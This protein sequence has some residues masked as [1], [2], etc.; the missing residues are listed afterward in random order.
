MIEAV[1]KIW[2]QIREN[3]QLAHYCTSCNHCH[4]GTPAEEFC[5]LLAAR[6]NGSPVTDEMLREVADRQIEYL[7]SLKHEQ[8][9]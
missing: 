1:V 7:R 4:R 8:T 6:E 2:E 3:P 9:G 5:E